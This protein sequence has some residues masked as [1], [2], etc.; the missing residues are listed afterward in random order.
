MAAAAKPASSIDAVIRAQRSLALSVAP[1]LCP[2]SPIPPPLATVASP[3]PQAS[4]DN[5]R[6]IAATPTLIVSRWSMLFS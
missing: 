4:A 3:P 1:S 2:A 6:A 5:N